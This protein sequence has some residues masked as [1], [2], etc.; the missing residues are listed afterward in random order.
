MIILN[1]SKPQLT[2]GIMELSNM[3]THVRLTTFL[4]L[5]LIGA[6]LVAEAD[7]SVS[8]SLVPP[9][10]LNGIVIDQ[11]SQKPLAGVTVKALTNGEFS[12]S[13]TTDEN[14][15]FRLLQLETGECQIL[16]SAAGYNEYSRSLDLQSNSDNV[17]EIKLDK[18]LIQLSPVVIIGESSTVSKQLTGT[19]TKISSESV[20]LIQPIGTQ[21]LLELVPGITGYADD[22]FGNSRLSIGIRGL[23]PRRSSRV[24]ILEDGVPIQPAVYVYPNVYY[25]PQLTELMR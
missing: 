17:L 19:A 10:S 12:T 16:V 8:T 7:K 15:Q 3:L 6:N 22:G 25:N 18:E 14:G 1:D 20:E 11:N 23:N 13:A 2:T 24:L 5:L 21:E 4:I 9:V